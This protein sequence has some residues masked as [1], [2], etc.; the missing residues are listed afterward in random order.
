M[1]YVTFDETLHVLELP[2]VKVAMTRNQRINSD[3]TS[4]GRRDYETIFNWLREKGVRNIIH[5]YVEDASPHSHSNESIE[6]ALKDFKIIKTWDW[7]KMDVDSETLLKAAPGVHEL[8]LYWSG[9]NAVLRG[10]SEPEG[11]DKLQYLEK[12]TV[13]GTQVSDVQFPFEVYPGFLN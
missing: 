5:L 11:L 10:W 3:E 2:N 13:H 7:C 8:V 4:K 9:S 6:R 1:P 12:I